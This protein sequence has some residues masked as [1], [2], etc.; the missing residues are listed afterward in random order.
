MKI[1][2]AAYIRVS[3]AEQKDDLQERAINEWARAKN[4]ELTFY[5]DA[6]TGTTMD[7]PGWRKLHA[8]IKAGKIGTLLVW[9]LDRVGRTAAGL[10]Q[11]FD[12]LNALGVKFISL[13]ESLDL[14]THMGKLVATV[15]SGVAEYETEVR[16]ERQTAG[17]AAAKA[18]GRKWGGSKP[19]WSKVKPPQAD[20]IR[21]LHSAGTSKM[22]IARIVGLSY[23]TVLKVVGSIAE[24][25]SPQ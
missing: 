18:A 1:R 5:R 9:K 10:I 12:E 7:R 17:I 11:L 4:V 3:T 19:G 20:A 15:L 16:R 22:E 23:P 24:Q 2:C 13:T 8:D 25:Q 6:F 21:K 14:S